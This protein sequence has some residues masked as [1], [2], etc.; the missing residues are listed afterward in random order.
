MVDPYAIDAEFYDLLHPDNGDDAD[1]WLSLA[2]A[3]EGPI[4]EAGTGTGRI[5]LRLAGAGHRVVGIDPSDAMLAIA[6][7]KA[8]EAGLDVQFAFGSLTTLGTLPRD[9]F[10]LV[11]VP[12]NV[13]L[14]CEHGE[15]QMEAL[16]AIAGALVAGGRVAIDLPGPAR[17]VDGMHNGEPVL[18]YSAPEEGGR[19]E[20]W[21]VH[22]DD[23]ATQTRVLSMRYER[24]RPDGTTWR[25]VSEQVL[26]YVYRFE[27]EYLLHLAGLRLLDV[28]GDYELGELTHESER[29]IFVAVRA[30]R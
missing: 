18:V 29:M 10:G 30:E 22:E 4:V 9:E 21:Q 24:T 17:F 2:G 26:R 20:V 5:A 15:D 8:D 12:A 19:L 13:F 3:A 11:I 23:L 28:F 6:R 1:F 7:A 27:M 14:H 16:R 25:A